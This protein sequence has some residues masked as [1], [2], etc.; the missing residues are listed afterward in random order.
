L[1]EQC[2]I[3]MMCISNTDDVRQVL[4]GEA[5]LIEDLGPGNL[6]IDLSTISPQATREFAERVQARGAF[7]LDAPVSGGSGGAAE[8]SL[9]IMIGGQADQIER[10]KPLFEA[11]GQTITHVGPNGHGQMA[12][13]VNQILVVGNMLTI[14]EALVFAAAGGLDLEKTLAAVSGGAA[15][16]WMLS[17]RAN[18]AI[19]GYWEPGFTVDLQQKDVKLA[20]TEAENLGVPTLVTSMVDSFYR[21]LQ[22]QGLGAEGNQAL[23][24][25]VEQLAGVK[26]RAS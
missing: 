15:G 14:S 3:V 5:G 20:L 2:D 1:A 12:K 8:G 24:K 26:A 17:N 10:A 21:V 22:R 23:I 25:A 19:A 18:Q 6:V 7:M 16:S 9:S 4:L 11:I 13:L